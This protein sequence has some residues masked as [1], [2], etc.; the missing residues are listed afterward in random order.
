MIRSLENMLIQGK[1][2]RTGL[3]NARKERDL[4]SQLYSDIAACFECM[5]DITR[6]GEF[7]L[8]KIKT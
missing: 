3:L 4:F 1:P 6:N 8:H 5:E 2:D 7:R